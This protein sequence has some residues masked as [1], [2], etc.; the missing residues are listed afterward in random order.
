MAHS[1]GCQVGLLRRARDGIR[2]KRDLREF[3]GIAEISASLAVER[4]NWA[5][6]VKAG[7]VFYEDLWGLN[8]DSHADGLTTEIGD[9]QSLISLA[10]RLIRILDTLKSEVLIPTESQPKV[11]VRPVQG[12]GHTSQ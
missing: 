4:K 1:A 3:P 11:A 2:V 9:A 10:E 7:W 6:R 8:P 12:F 5:L